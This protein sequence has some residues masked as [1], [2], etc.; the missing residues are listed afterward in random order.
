MN[1]QLRIVV[2]CVLVLSILSC[3]E[4]SG[5]SFQ[6][7]GKVTNIERLIAQYPSSFRNDSLKL[8]LYEVP[9][10]NEL[11]PVQLDST[12]VTAKNNLF[13]LSGTTQQVGMLDI[14]LENGPMI[15][16]VNDKPE[17]SVEI[18]LD[19]KENFYSVKGSPA[20]QQLRDFIV[21]Y[22][23]KSN[24]PETAF[25]NLD[26]LKLQNQNDSSLIGATD[27]KNKSLEAINSFSFQDQVE[28]APVFAHANTG[29][30]ST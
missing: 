1:R 28:N 14:M 13:E 22:T 16:L 3:K 8:Y 17:V 21:G 18:D 27:Q 2:I 12:Y 23:E 11:P 4:K 15:P 10:G 19:N 24:A 20:S 25:K 6:V 7:K 29:A 9:F 30:F 26:S 5:D